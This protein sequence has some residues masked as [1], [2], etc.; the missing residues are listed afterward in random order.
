MKINFSVF[1]SLLFFSLNTVH[2]DEQKTVFLGHLLTPT[3]YTPKKNVVT[4]GTHIIS[5]SPSDSLMLGTASFLAL[6][7]NTP[8]LFLK[9]GK[10][11]SEKSR[12]ALQVDYF[13]SS[14]A[15]LFSNNTFYEMEGA[16]IWGLWSTDLNPIYT[17]HYSLN[18]MYFINEGKPHS[19]R[20]EPFNDQPYQ[21]T[22]TTLHEVKVTEKFGIAAEAGIL[23]I[24]YVIP[25]IHLGVTFRYTGKNFLVQAGFSI[26]RHLFSSDKAEAYAAENLILDLSH[27][28]SSLTHPEFGFQY[29]F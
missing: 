12:W 25:N 9:Y 3:T 4:A 24:N 13:K 19:L 16:M 26:D 17:I 18:Y 22:F 8:N 14:S 15:Q 23:G 11:Y 21:F 5:Y 6:F 27:T 7:Y 20:R 29:F 10:Q 1:L 2:A 28:T